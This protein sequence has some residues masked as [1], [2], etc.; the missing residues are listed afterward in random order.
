MSRACQISVELQ[1]Q[2]YRVVLPEHLIKLLVTYVPLASLAHSLNVRSS[3]LVERLGDIET[4]GGKPLAN[5]AVREALVR[6][7][8][9]SLAALLPERACAT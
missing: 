7:S 1:P 8:D 2:P 9:L 5:G 4:L 6:L 3:D